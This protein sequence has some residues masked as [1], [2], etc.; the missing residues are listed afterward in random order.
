MEENNEKLVIIMRGITGSGKTTYLQNNYPNAFIC[1]ANDYFT[2]KDGNYNFIGPE[3]PQSHEYCKNAFVAALRNSLS[4]IAVDNTAIKLWEFDFYLQLAEMYGYN[5][6]VVRMDGDP[7]I[8]NTRSI[9]G[10]PESR[11]VSIYNNIESYPQEE[12]I[13]S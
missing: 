12:I 8:A 13:K 5:V 11:V 7:A 3:V 2:D 4:L 1:S 9:R 10:I 6:R